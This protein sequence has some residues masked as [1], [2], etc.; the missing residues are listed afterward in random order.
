M[1]TSAGGLTEARRRPVAPHG[2]ALGVAERLV[3]VSLRERAGPR[4]R[5][6][7]LSAT[8]SILTGLSQEQLWVRQELA[9]TAGLQ[10]RLGIYGRQALP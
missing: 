5:P 10:S 6:F 3:G 7:S 2:L 1:S 8:R 9:F 4:E